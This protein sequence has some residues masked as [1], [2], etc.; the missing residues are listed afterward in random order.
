M[1]ASRERASRVRAICM[2]RWQRGGRTHRVPLERGR[3]HLPDHAGIADGRALRRLGRCRPAEPLG[4]GAR[5]RR[6]AIGGRRGGRNARCV[7]ARGAGDDVHGIARTAVDGTEHVQDRGRTDARGHPRRGTHRR[8]SRALDL[9]R[10]QRRHAR[11]NDRLGHA[12]LRIGPG[13]ARLRARLTRRD[14]ARPSAVPALLRRL[15]HIARDEQG[16]APR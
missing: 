4:R 1:G 11:A 6:D 3:F 15:P 10:S 13:G 9:R 5:R 8:H 7:A 16:L 12:R 2:H 14:P